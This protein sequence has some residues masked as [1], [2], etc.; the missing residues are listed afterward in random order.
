MYRVYVRDCVRLGFV[1]DCVCVCVWLCLYILRVCD[2]KLA[3]CV[4]VCACGEVRVGCCV[5]M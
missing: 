3:C 5:R 4:C 2:W 1:H